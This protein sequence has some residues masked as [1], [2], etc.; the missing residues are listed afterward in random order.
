[1]KDQP[2]PTLHP[3][4]AALALV[5]AFACSGHSQGT[6]FTYQ[7]RLL[8]DGVPANG[9][10]YGMDFHLY[11]SPTNDL[12]FG[13]VSVEGVVVSNGLFT[14][15]LDFGN[16]FSGDA[17]WM[18][19][20][21]RKSGD[22]AV[23][24]TPRQLITSTP[25]AVMAAGASNLLGTLPA[26]Q[27]TGVMDLSRLPAQVVTNNATGLNLTGSFIGGVSNLVDTS[28]NYWG[29]FIGAG[30]SNLV[31][32]F[33]SSIVGGFQNNISDSS[34]NYAADAFIGGGFRNHIQGDHS[35]IGGGLWNTNA[36]ASACIGSGRLNQ[37]EAGFDG[38][39]I[40]AGNNNRVA[41]INSSIV[42]GYQ[43][44]ISDPPDGFMVDAFI[45]GGLQ[46]HAGANHTVIA[47]GLNNTNLGPG[48]TVGGGNANWV[49]AAANDVF[50]GGGYLNRAEG[51]RGV[52]S[53]GQANRVETNADY[54][55][56]GGG[57]RNQIGSYASL[58]TIGGGISNAVSPN[59]AYA[60]IPGGLL[61]QATNLAFAAGRRAK[62]IHS[63]SFVWGDST[64]TD[65]ASTSSNQFLIR[66]TGGVGIG[67]NDPGSLLDVGGRIRLRQ[68]AGSTNAAGSAG[69]WLY[70]NAPAAD[71]GFMGMNGDGYMGFWG[72]K[73]ASWGMLMN[74]TNGNL[75]VVGTVTANG[76]LL[77][78]DRNAKENFQSLNR[79]EVLAKLV[80]LPVSQWNYKQE[81]PSQKHIGP[82]AQD[83]Q[84][85]FGLNGN[86]DRH[87]S[88][89]DEA[90]VAL[91]AIQGLN[92]KLENK[93]GDAASRLRALEK[94]NAE[95]RQQLAELRALLVGAIQSK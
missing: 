71:R 8:D 57:R 78:S 26:T 4:I 7:G 1:M 72:A 18:G 92:E 23:L 69:L 80:D 66:A 94:E 73:G 45:G 89:V 13:S 28:S 62:A 46:N 5:L 3:L 38:G 63:G 64:D 58:A 41:A 67:V 6:A 15:T 65:V 2:H 76:V 82:M 37:I 32:A 33:N 85:A 70:Q 43:N 35:V 31:A 68:D 19:I 36:S 54:A 75:A 81:S 22:S 29:G 12:R 91:A 30:F 53:G 40:G 56:I 16:V 86:D 20:W 84:A 55:T 74:I 39:F 27:L 60:I 93:C 49:G 24:L 14:V 59:G 25:Y 48:A 47:G 52:I 79:Q 10:N 44:N 17:R 21:V 50:I 42:G 95:L 34:D 77:T 9:T 51:F 11:D 87:I 83:F 61:N 90:G 88:V